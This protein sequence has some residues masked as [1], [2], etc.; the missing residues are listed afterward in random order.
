MEVIVHAD[1]EFKYRRAFADIEDELSDELAGEY[2]DD[3]D[4]I[5]R[6]L[7]RV[8]KNIHPDF[9]NVRIIKV[10]PSFCYTRFWNTLEN[11]VIEN[12]LIAFYF[13]KIEPVIN[14][15]E[16][17]RYGGGLDVC[18]DELLTRN[19]STIEKLWR[20]G[21]YLSLVGFKAIFNHFDGKKAH[22]GICINI[23]CDHIMTVPT[24]TYQL[25]CPSCGRNT[26]ISPIH[27]KPMA[28]EY[29]DR[30]ARI[31]AKREALC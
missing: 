17:N 18:I 1:P 12:D 13:R 24:D 14:E 10:D 28:D 16:K 26:V 21:E 27:L 19:S 22:E 5:N 23:G 15:M 2:W 7:K 20:L 25:K 9:P 8:D 29:K 6:V 3:I 4:E 30:I 11:N 31:K